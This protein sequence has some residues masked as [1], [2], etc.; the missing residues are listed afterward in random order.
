[1][2]QDIALKVS[3]IETLL[4]AGAAA[5]PAF[6]PKGGEGADRGIDIVLGAQWGD[7]GKG[8]LVDVL[9]QV[10]VFACVPLDCLLQFGLV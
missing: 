5:N 10:G 9:S 6:S 3:N 8:K 4:G 2:L 7:E 1:M